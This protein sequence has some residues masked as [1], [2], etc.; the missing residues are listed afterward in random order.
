M[1]G[2]I[3]IKERLFLHRIISPLRPWITASY[4]RE[5]LHRTYEG[6]FFLYGFDRVVTTARS[7]FA[8]WW[9]IGSLCPD[10]VIGREIVLVLMEER[11]EEGFHS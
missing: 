7:I 11:E 10:R 1:K 3:K 4:P 5:S 2:I 9:V 8:V 6:S